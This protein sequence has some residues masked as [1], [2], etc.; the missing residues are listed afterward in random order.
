MDNGSPQERLASW[1][2]ELDPEKH[3]ALGIL[4][5]CGILS[6]GL[7]FAYLRFH[8]RSPFF[9]SRALVAAPGA[10]SGPTPGHADSTDTD[11]DGLSD[12]AEMSVHQTSPY[13]PDT[14]SDGLTDGQEVALQSDPNCPQ[15]QACQDA[16]SAPVGTASSTAGSGSPFS[17][18]FLDQT[19][20]SPATTSAPLIPPAPE[21]L[22]A[23]QMRAYF[24]QTGLVDP[25]ILQNL[26]DEAVV[27]VYRAAYAEAERI[28]AA[29][30]P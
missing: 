2:R 12:A 20:P 17:P 21:T 29:G 23:I 6:L 18:S 1:W 16:A 3:A 11:Q 14:D 7:S 4:G 25:D 22:T 30:Q 10:S 19:P 15:G 8:V 24:Q 13:L 26:S 27:Q 5:V 9:V 28:Q